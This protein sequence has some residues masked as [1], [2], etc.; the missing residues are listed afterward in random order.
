[1]TKVLLIED[2]PDQIFLY[3]TKFKLENIDAVNA[4]SGAKGI[5]MAASE[6]P[7]LILLDMLMD[8]MGGIEVL[9]KLKA[10]AKTKKI[11]VVMLTNLIKK[12]LIDQAKAL[13]AIDFWPK[14]EV[15]PSEIV[16]RVKKI[17]KI[18]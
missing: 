4:P 7:N 15:M 16:E 5:E 10:D 1:M 11:P 12:E 18:K 2:D 8:D 17:L 3:T 13:G 9:T 6:Q 14:A